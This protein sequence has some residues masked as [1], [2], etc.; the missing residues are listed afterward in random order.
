M[1]K[2]IKKSKKDQKQKNKV[3]AYL[4]FPDDMRS[5]LPICCCFRLI[6]IISDRKIECFWGWLGTLP[7]VLFEY[8]GTLMVILPVI[9]GYSGRLTDV[10]NTQYGHQGQHL[11][12][13][14]GI[15]DTI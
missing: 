4:L 6:Y 1:Q 15:V 9:G 7:R 12:R 8:L 14:L 5:D 3:T 13:L 11:Q 10:F 2:T